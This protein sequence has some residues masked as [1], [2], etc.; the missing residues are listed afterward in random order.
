MLSRC[1]QI[2]ICKWP[3]VKVCCYYQNYKLLLWTKKYINISV[4]A[5]TPSHLIGNLLSLMASESIESVYCV[6]CGNDLKDIPTERRNLGSYSLAIPEPREHGLSSWTSLLNQ[7]LQ[8]QCTTI[9]S[10]IK[11]PANPGRMCR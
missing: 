3:N 10:Y 7:E 11:D 2:A 1:D 6:G 5:V 9:E 8:C 4:G